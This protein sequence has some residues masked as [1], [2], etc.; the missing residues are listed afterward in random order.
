MNKDL[1]G[2]DIITNPLLRE[3]YG[4]IPVSILDTCSI[5]W[6]NRKRNWLKLGIESEISRNNTLGFSKLCNTVQG[7]K[8]SHK[9]VSV[10]DATL[11]EL[12]YRWF[13]PENGNIIDPFAGGSVRG[14][15][16]NYLG[17]KYTGIELRKEQVDSKRE[18]ALNILPIEKQPQWY[19]G[20]SEEI[21]KGE[22]NI[23]FDFLFSCPPY[24]DLEVYSNDEND[25]SNLK[26][27]EF[28]SKY[29]SIILNSCNLLKKGKY[30]CFVVG[31]VR[32]K[33]TGYYK[34]FITI[35]KM[36]FYK[37]GMKLYNEMILK[38]NIG[39]A[40]IRVSKI[41]DS[42]QKIVKCHQNVLIFIKP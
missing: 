12:M 39:S 7:G 25:L 28:I 4:E 3:K 23:S 31:D 15:I 8:D 42:K 9:N 33:K 26:D 22:W 34:D 13:C 18:Q 41:F 32:D 37:A 2:N 6:I 29:E 20:D 21:L 5:T 38:N 14:I 10:F 27:D 36:A 16:A 17:F 1:F 35:T 19:I 30:A 24:M 11:T 40:A